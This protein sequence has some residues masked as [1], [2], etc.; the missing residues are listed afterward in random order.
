M[1]QVDFS[2]ELDAGALT[3]PS[4]KAI[5][6]PCFYHE[7]GCNFVPCGGPGATGLSTGIAFSYAGLAPGRHNLTVRSSDI[8]G[9]VADVISW[10]FSVDGC[11]SANSCVASTPHMGPIRD[12]EN[13]HYLSLVDDNICRRCKPVIGC[14]T[15]RTHCTNR[16]DSICGDCESGFDDPTS[17]N[18]YD[19]SFVSLWPRE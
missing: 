1:L 7:S 14:D 19:C 13:R 6:R 4:Q 15:D 9:N 18:M 11:A 3:N 5:D 2:C 8:A 16:I 12:C 10:I 17:K